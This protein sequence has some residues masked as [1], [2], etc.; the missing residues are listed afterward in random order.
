MRVFLQI[1]SRKDTN[2][3]ISLCSSYHNLTMYLLG[4]GTIFLAL[5]SLR[6]INVYKAIK[7]YSSKYIRCQIYEGLGGFAVFPYQTQEVLSYIFPTV[8]LFCW[9]LGV[10]KFGI[11]CLNFNWED[12]ESNGWLKIEE[13]DKKIQV[14]CT[15]LTSSIWIIKL[16]YNGPDRHLCLRHSFKILHLFQTSSWL[17]SSYTEILSGA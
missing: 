6:R 13:H 16:V 5:I 2:H 17:C 4:H 7:D 11:F 15:D 14:E 10:K 12:Q 8:R 1:S 9:E 3:E